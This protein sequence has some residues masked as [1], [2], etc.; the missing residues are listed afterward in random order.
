MRRLLHKV[1]R[2][3]LIRMGLLAGGFLLILY[4]NPLYSVILNR[5]AASGSAVG[6]VSRSAF[7]AS[8]P[9]TFASAGLAGNFASTLESMIGLGLIG[10]ALVLEVLSLYLPAPAAAAANAT[11]AVTTGASEETRKAQGEAGV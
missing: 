2:L 11:A 6:S 8:G 3:V 1:S 9:S 10:I 5:T 4:V 7:A